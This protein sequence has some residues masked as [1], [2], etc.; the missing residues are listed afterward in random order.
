MVP[1]LS[2]TPPPPHPWLGN[3]KC[4]EAKTNREKHLRCESYCSNEK[5]KKH[6]RLSQNGPPPTSPSP[7]RYTKTATRPNKSKKHFIGVFMFS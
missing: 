6:M 2:P 4:H 7:A 5:Y 1:N 3:K